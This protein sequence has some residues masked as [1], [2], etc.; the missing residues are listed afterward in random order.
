MTTSVVLCI[1]NSLTLHA[2]QNLLGVSSYDDQKTQNDVDSIYSG[3]TSPFVKWASCKCHGTI[4]FKKF[5]ILDDSGTYIESVDST[6]IE[7]KLWTSLMCW[8]YYGLSEQ[9]HNAS[10]VLIVWRL[11]VFH[12]E[13][14]FI[15]LLRVVPQCCPL[16][17]HI[18]ELLRGE[19]DGLGWE[20]KA[21]REHSFGS[22]VGNQRSPSSSKL[23]F[24]WQYWSRRLAGN[25][26]YEYR[27]NGFV[28]TDI[29]R[30]VCWSS[31]LSAMA[32][33]NLFW[34]VQ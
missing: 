11:T 28:I 15:S 30:R 3:F 14:W 20:D 19:Q 24:S 22:G 9:A 17:G 33:F 4:W 21:I 2:T 18:Y 32:V 31:D 12:R 27:S 1:S 26:T 6:E 25:L 13:C 8:I 7:T 34:M 23:A 5:D 29:V 10:L 16:L